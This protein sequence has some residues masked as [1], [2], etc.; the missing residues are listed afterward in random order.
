MLLSRPRQCDFRL[1]RA[2]FY[3]SMCRGQVLHIC[4]AQS[5]AFSRSTIRHKCNIFIWTRVFSNKIAWI[6]G[7]RRCCD[8]D[9]GCP[10]RHLS[11]PVGKLCEIFLYKRRICFFLFA[12][13]FCQ[14]PGSLDRLCERSFV[15]IHRRNFRREHQKRKANSDGFISIRIISLLCTRGEF[16]FPKKLR[17]GTARRP[18]LA[19]AP[20]LARCEKLRC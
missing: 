15:S 11:S 18:F 3:K 10:L 6:Y 16:I 20:A 8:S 5:K 9:S 17:T 13:C 14:S 2:F 7:V 4:P 12:C 19:P 1:E